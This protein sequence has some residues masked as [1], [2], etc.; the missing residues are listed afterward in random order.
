[1]S[2]YQYQKSVRFMIVGGR[3]ALEREKLKKRIKKKKNLFH[4]K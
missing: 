2:G 3:N 1:M 4:P